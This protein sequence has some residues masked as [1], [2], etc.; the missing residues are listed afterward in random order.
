MSKLKPLL[1]LICKL[2]TAGDYHCKLTLLSPLD[3]PYT[4]KF[5][6]VWL[7]FVLKSHTQNAS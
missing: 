2:Q 4:H 5:K 7:H 3:S 6:L 1:I